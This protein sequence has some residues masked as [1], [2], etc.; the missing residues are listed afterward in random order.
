MERKVQ[1]H[2]KT[3]DISN[4]MKKVLKEREEKFGNDNE[5]SEQTFRELDEKNKELYIENTILKIW[6]GN[7]NFYVM[8]KQLML[9]ARN[10]NPG[11]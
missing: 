4:E 5:I 6:K 10:K 7:L 9:W 3:E 8:G 2:K 1:R 11:D